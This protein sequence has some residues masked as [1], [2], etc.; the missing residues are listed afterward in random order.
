MAKR[1]DKP[2]EVVKVEAPPQWLAEAAETDQS[3]EAMAE[4]R[5]LPR[6]KVV[7]GMSDSALKDAV[8][9]GGVVLTPGN[10]LVC[11][12]DEGF[13]F[14]PVFFFTEFIEMSDINDSESPTVLERTF[15]VTH[16]LAVRAR[17]ADQWERD[18]GPEDSKGRAKYTARA[19]E[20]FNFVGFLD[21]GDIPA[22]L[23]GV[24]LTITFAR[25]EFNTGRS[26]ITAITMRRVGGKIVPLWAQRWA[27]TIGF[28]ERDSKKW[29]GLDVR[30][31]AQPYISEEQGAMF[32]GAHEEFAELFEKQ[33]LSVDHEDKPADAE[34]VEEGE[35]ESEF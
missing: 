15:D 6:L 26:F 19:C 20:V 28:R 2:K 25:G 29:Y 22:E 31:P 30:N 4:H 7:Q 9:E 1:D 17:D 3:I 18:Y 11:S 13:E 32:K 14:V 5:V 21:G 12:R 24:P 8:G 33:R 27:F 10:V 34:I 23:H 16:P 35:D